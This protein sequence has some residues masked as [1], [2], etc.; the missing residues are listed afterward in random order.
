MVNDDNEKLRTNRK[1]LLNMIYSEFDKFAD[2][3][4]I[5]L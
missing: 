2:F 3:K 4:Q 5:T 1:Q